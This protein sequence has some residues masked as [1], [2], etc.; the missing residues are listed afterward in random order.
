[1]KALTNL[2]FLLFISLQ[3]LITPVYS[4]DIEK[5]DGIKH[6]HNGEPEW[7]ENSK[8]ALEH[9]MTIGGIDVVDEDYLMFDILDL[10]QDREGNIYIVD[11]GNRRIQKYNSDGKYLKTIGR[12]GQGP[13]EF[14]FPKFIC[15]HP[16]GK[17]YINDGLGH[18]S[19]KVFNANKK[20]N[21]RFLVKSVFSGD[22]RLIDSD[23]ILL[24]GGGFLDEWGGG[25]KDKESNP[26]FSIITENGELTGKFGE[27]VI[28]NYSTNPKGQDLF[29]IDGR[30]PFDIDSEGNIFITYAIKNCIEKR[31]SGGE[32]LFQA[33]RKLNYKI[34]DFERKD[35]VL[36]YPNVSSTC[37][38]IDYADR[39][40][41]STIT[42][43]PE[44]WDVFYLLKK[45]FAEF[46]IYDS[47]GVL[48]GKL[49]FPEDLYRFRI[50]G[51]NM[52]I[53]GYDRVSVSKYKI[54]SNNQN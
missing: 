7:G 50:I 49:P 32:I 44:K 19:I 28:F 5:I 43:Q 48:L 26:L 20:E 39:V 29:K 51:D 17:I 24:G 46:E 34:T 1:M 11:T 9:V 40:W 13:D 37:L 14:V 31:D 47:E 33:D 38:S 22:I 4:Q 35:G 41:I 2:L 53:I 25:L 3:I 12:R 16:S 45:E 52:Y 10:D 23:R 42:K 21:K 27:P 15:I 6:I 54:I 18:N 8:V 30:S 36:L